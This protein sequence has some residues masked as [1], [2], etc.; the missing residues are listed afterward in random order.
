MK[1]NRAAFFDLDG[2]ILKCQIERNFGFKLFLKGKIKLMSLLIIILNDIK[3]KFCKDEE[4]IGIYKKMI[5]NLIS[6]VNKEDFKK[7]FSEYYS[8]KLKNKIYPEVFRLVRKFKNNGYE[9]YIV[10]SFIEPV[11]SE[12]A[13]NINA[14][15]CISTKLKVK[16]NIYTGS[17]NDKVYI[18]ENKAKAIRK[19]S[20]KK[21]I[22]LS[23]SYA[24]GDYIHDTTYIFETVGVPI[25]VNPDKKLLDIAIKR[26]W[27]VENW[28]LG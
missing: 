26:N 28:L 14:D 18:G 10:S 23:D 22:N 27:K 8:M 24:F 2:T 9:I 15:G 4:K 7:E 21:N 3:L 19:L 1:K 12:F 16:S 17:I 6:N 20:N 13:K 11:V 5:S 25:V